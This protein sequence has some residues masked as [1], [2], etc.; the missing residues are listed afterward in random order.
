MRQIIL[1]FEEVACKYL[2]KSKIVLKFVVSIEDFPFAYV[3]VYDVFSHVK[4]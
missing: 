1:V 2:A 3:Q 4:S